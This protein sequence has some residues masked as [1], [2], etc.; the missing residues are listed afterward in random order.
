MYIRTLFTSAFFLAITCFSLQ[1]NVD[2]G[3]VVSS[4]TSGQ[5]VLLLALNN[6]SM[7]PGDR[8]DRRADRID[9]RRGNDQDA[10]QCDAADDCY[11]ACDDDDDDCWDACDG[12]YPDCEGECDAADDCYD[13]CDDDDD[14][15]WDACDDKYPDC[16]DD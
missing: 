12:Q 11:D 8:R 9:A 13:E 1:A 15:C 14:D 3:L 16:A 6:G 7:G 4:D 10:D 2:T 5:T